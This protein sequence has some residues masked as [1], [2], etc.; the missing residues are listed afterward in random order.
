LDGIN[1]KEETVFVYSAGKLVAEYSTKPPP[2]NPTTSYT[3]TDQLGSPRVITDSLGN[4][5]SRRDFMPF[6]E[7]IVNNIGERA[8]ASLK[9]GVADGVRQKFTGYLK[10]DET[11]LDFAE[12]R[13]YENRH[14]RFT[15]VD[16]LLASGRSASPQSFNRFVYVQN[17]PIVKIDP[18]GLIDWFSRSNSQNGRTEWRWSDDN[19]SFKDGTSTEGW[20]QHQF[21]FTGEIRVDNACVNANCSEENTAYLR[22][23]GKIEREG[24]LR[25]MR[26]EVLEE[27]PRNFRRAATTEN[28]RDSWNFFWRDPL[29]EQ[30]LGSP[31]LAFVTGGMASE[32]Q[33]VKNFQVARAAETT[34]NVAN[35]YRSTTIAQQ[36]GREGMRIAVAF[37]YRRGLFSFGRS[38]SEA[39]AAK[40]Y[41]NESMK[42]LSEEALATGKNLGRSPRNCCEFKAVNELLNLGSRRKDIIF[43]VLDLGDGTMVPPCEFCRI[44]TAGTRPIVGN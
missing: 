27:F 12:A 44:T 26:Q 19:K 20:S 10:D 1:V 16:P 2:S 43:K 41:L 9:Y 6:G 17:N 40:Q 13:M 39:K 7:E 28:V 21:P 31:A 33:M 11:S 15:A 22:N 8:A 32:A 35:W 14:G 23:G 42:I 3:A 18:T 34:S 25:T 37:D 29:G 4:V 38:G 36:E 24:F 5:I 30:N